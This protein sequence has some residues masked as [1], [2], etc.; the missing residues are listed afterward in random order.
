MPRNGSGIYTR[1]DGTRTG[2][3]VW[4]QARD[5]GVKLVADGHD[6]QDQDI[7][8]AITA[9]IAKD[10]QTT[11]TANLPMGT[12]RHTGVGNASA[13]T[14]YAAA[15]QTQDGKLNWADSGGTAD[16]IT[17]TYAPALTAL[18]NGQLCHVRA[19]FA[20][21]TTTPTFAPNGLTARTI[22]K[23]GGSALAV[24]DIMGDGH[25]LV[26]R[27]DLANTRWEFV[28]VGGEKFKDQDIWCGV[29][30]GTADAITLTPAVAITA[31]AIGQ[32]FAWL[33]SASPNT[34]PM[35][36]AISGLSTI[37][38]QNDG[39]ALAAGEHVANKLYIGVLDTAST[40]QISHVFNSVLDVTT[41]R[42]N[43][44]TLFADVADQLTAGFTGTSHNLGNLSTATT[45]HISDGNMQHGT[46]T[47]SFTLTAPDDT[48]VGYV[49]IELTIDGTGGYT[50]TLS[51]FET[52]T[53]T[54][55][56]T[57][58]T[59]NLLQITK[60]NGGTGIIITQKA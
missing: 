22:V 39:S 30:T 37:A 55:V 50:L 49:E 46:M 8:D 1:T 29:A 58:A 34:G 13:R 44:D 19:G 47:G 60:R 2:A 25:E 15:G 41:Q 4:Q 14:D 35:T 56:Y 6:T 31:Y 43:V 51:G 36:V 24:G 17:A 53:G 3:T 10:G 27:Y 28:N 26:L 21:A 32:R 54:M 16:A 12:Y 11:P 48:G 45:L 7:A 23:N 20:N 59:V 52:P 57:A 40:I 42:Y 33:A 9:S 18:V 5:A 38:A